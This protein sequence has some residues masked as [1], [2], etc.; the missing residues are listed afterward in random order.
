[1][2]PTRTRTQKAACAVCLSGT[3]AVSRP[4]ELYMQL[5]AIQPALF[6]NWHDFTGA[7]FCTTGRWLIDEHD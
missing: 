4:A 2:T 7:S 1:M 5:H 6:S 3:P